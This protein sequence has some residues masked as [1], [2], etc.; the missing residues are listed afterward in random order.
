MI[1][2]LRLI[3]VFGAGLI[4]GLVLT[5]GGDTSPVEQDDPDAELEEVA[6]EATSILRGQRYPGDINDPHFWSEIVDD[7]MAENI[8]LKDE[9]GFYREQEQRE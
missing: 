5:S 3:A 6:T 2:A 1:S 8:W 9:L 7:F 4:L